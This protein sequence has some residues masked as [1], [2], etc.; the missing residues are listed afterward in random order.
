MNTNK[1]EI[2]IGRIGILT[3]MITLVIFLLAGGI[4]SSAAEFA[5]GDGTAEDP[6]VIETVAELDRV[7]EELD[8]H[9]ILSADL[10]LDELTE[11][12]EPIG[13]LDNRFQG[14]FDG[15]GYKITELS[16]SD[17]EANELGLF[18]AI[19][20]EGQV[21][22]LTIEEAN[23]YG[24]E[25]IGILA[26]FNEGLVEDSSAAGEVEAVNNHL[27]GLVGVNQTGTISRS[28]A[29]VEVTGN[30][31]NAGGLVGSNRFDSTIKDSY[32]R[33]EILAEVNAAGG[34]VGENMGDVSYSYASAEVEGGNL[35]G[36]MLGDHFEGE[37]ISS[38]YDYEVTGFEDDGPGEPVSTDEMKQQA[39]F[40]DWDFTETWQIDEG[41]GYP[42][43]Q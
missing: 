36:G 4:H 2:K 28:S 32:A 13:D 38:Y 8:S 6:Y 22:D 27:G 10:S 3:L 12:W 19:G 25:A 1:G 30:S 24:N 37:I 9:F 21:S 11:D 17:S 29:Y 26:G 43:H 34:L 20:P 41:E 16:I 15:K 5:A 31:N 39:T 23:I 14:T 33:G 35:V 40:V 42:E 18:G 7:R